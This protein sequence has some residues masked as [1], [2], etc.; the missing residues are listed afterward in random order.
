MSA[1]LQVELGSR[2]NRLAIYDQLINRNDPSSRVNESVNQVEV[3]N[4][5]VIVAI[6]EEDGRAKTLGRLDKPAEQETQKTFEPTLGR[7][8][9]PTEHETQSTSELNFNS[10]LQSTPEP[11]V[12]SARSHGGLLSDGNG[13]HSKCS[14]TPAPNSRPDGTSGGHGERCSGNRDVRHDPGSAGKSKQVKTTPAF[15]VVG[16]VETN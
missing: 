14:F 16:P 2:V 5:E 13:D 8:D 11:S 10:L 12:D 15:P 3:A 7:L 6:S 4:S 1:D 9:Q